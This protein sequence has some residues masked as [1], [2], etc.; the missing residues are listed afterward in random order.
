MG[1]PF[2]DG[3]LAY[4]RFTDESGI[5]LGAPTQYLDEPLD[6]LVPSD[7]GVEFIGA[8]GCGKVDA[9]LVQRRSFAG[10][11]GEPG[12]GCPLGQDML[13]FGASPFEGDT[14]AVQHA[15]G[16]AFS[17]AQQTQQQVLGADVVMTHLAGLVYGKLDDFLGSGSKAGLAAA[18]F[19]TA[20]DDELNRRAYLAQA[21]SQ[22]GKDPGGYPLF[23]TYQPE[24]DMLG[25]DV[26]VVEVACLFLSYREDA[27]GSF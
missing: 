3:R 15:G 21:D 7:N 6:F 9:Q 8:G 5:V 24:Q 19:L 14:E 27:A 18:R 20:P 2:N 26:A 11:A 22:V 17:F 1:Q 13:C 23:L 4:A 16:H 10:A 12:L 25:A